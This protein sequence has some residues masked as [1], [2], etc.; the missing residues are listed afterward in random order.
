[1]T[2]LWRVWDWWSMWDWMVPE[3]PPT[4]LSALDASHADR[5]AE[6]HG[7][8]FARPWSAGEF[9]DFMAERAIRCDGIFVGRDR[10]PAG[11]VLTRVGADQAEIISVTLAVGMRGR[12]YARQLLAHQLQG[13]ADEGVAEVHLEVEDGNRA[14]LA[15]Y[16]RL[17]FRE[18]GRREGYY[19]RPD[20]SRTGA[21]TMTRV[22]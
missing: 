21:I 7:N 22:L 19:H 2:T 14:A 11:F 3:P 9:E 18:T 1:M 10:Q 13:L 5:L 15:L 4:H 6:L 8:A 17:G 20:G 16:K 12:G